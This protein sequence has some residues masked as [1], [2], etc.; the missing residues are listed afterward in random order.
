MPFLAAIP[1]A[2]GASA[3]VST[4]VG[5]IGGALGGAISGGEDQ[6]NTQSSVSR[7]LVDKESEQERQARLAAQQGLGE[8]QAGISAGPGISDVA[9]GATSQR[10]LASQLQMLSQQGATPSAQD[11]SQQEALAGRLFAGRRQAVTSNFMEQQQQSAQQAALMGR[12][13]LDPVL[14]NN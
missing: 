12:S 11:I 5:A 14:S 13:P 8:F 9:A 3:G 1:A 2:L 4:A 7:V 6:T 10:D